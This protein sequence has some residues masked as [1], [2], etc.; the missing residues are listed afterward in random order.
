[1]PVSFNAMKIV[2]LILVTAFLCIVIPS[3]CLSSSI[4]TDYIC[5]GNLRNL[6]SALEMYA[7][8][9]SGRFPVLL[10][11]LTPNYIRVIPY[12][13]T[14]GVDTYSCGY[15]GKEKDFFLC[16]IGKNHKNLPEN[17]P[18]YIHNQ[19]LI[20]GRTNFNS[21]SIDEEEK[22]TGIMT[23]LILLGLLSLT[24]YIVYRKK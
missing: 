2:A 21:G 23:G 18:A 11:S 22:K 17:S 5:E 3:I 7:N 14:A 24:S 8:D 6:A 20:S 10:S 13:P 4:T 19:G 1:M 16:C 15:M 12:C 9:N